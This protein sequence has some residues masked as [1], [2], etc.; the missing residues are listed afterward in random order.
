MFTYTVHYYYREE[1]YSFT[2]KAPKQIIKYVERALA[3]NRKNIV[4][5]NITVINTDDNI[6]RIYTYE[7]FKEKYK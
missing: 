3:K 4:I 6:Y 5:N 1:F 2:S 7:D